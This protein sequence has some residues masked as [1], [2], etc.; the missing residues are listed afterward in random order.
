MGNKPKVSVNKDDSIQ[1]EPHKN[2]KGFQKALL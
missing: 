2:A 1:F